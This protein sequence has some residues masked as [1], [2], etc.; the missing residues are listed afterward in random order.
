[1]GTCIRFWLGSKDGIKS[2]FLN[3]PIEEFKLWL[4]IYG[5]EFNVILKEEVCLLIDNI[6]K[7][8]ETYL[9]ANNEKEAEIIDRMMDCFYSN[10][11]DL[12]RQDLLIEAEDSIVKI[13]RYEESYKY[14]KQQCDSKET[15]YLDYILQG[16]GIGRIMGL[17][18]YKSE[19]GVCKTG[20]LASFECQ[21][22]KLL[23]EKSFV[24]LFD[25]FVKDYN[26]CTI[27]IT[28]DALLTACLED[29]GLI[30]TIA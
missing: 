29:T 5:G 2:H 1:M 4:E 24:P 23:L 18:P 7:Y 8:G 28:Y 20:Y 27:C 26:Y 25:I 12:E 15:K 10:F 13:H 14:I 11:C 19:D 30:I 17:Y 16:R 3:S 6:I 21:Q 9:Q 22:L